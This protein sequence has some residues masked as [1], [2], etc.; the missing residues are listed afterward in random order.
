M[1]KVI[2]QIVAEYGNAFAAL[3]DSL[4]FVGENDKQLV[5][6]FNYTV[7]VSVVNVPSPDVTIYTGSTN[8]IA[9]TVTRTVA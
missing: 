6:D 7:S 2:N 4:K 1:S 3:E 9:V 8:F 5:Y